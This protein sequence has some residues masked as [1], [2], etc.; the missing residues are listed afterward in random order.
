MTYETFLA[1]LTR[2]RLVAYRA[3][4]VSCVGNAKQWQARHE[5]LLACQKLRADNPHHVQT[6][7]LAI[8][9]RHLAAT[10]PGDGVA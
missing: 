6:Q 1:D 5:A 4:H 10:A 8:A 3:Y 2:L 7:K 9:V